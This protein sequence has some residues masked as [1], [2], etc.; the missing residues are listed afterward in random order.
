MPE[1]K[2]ANLAL[3]GGGTHGAFTW[4]VLQRL[5]EEPRFEI[6]GLSATSAGAMNAAVLAHGLTVGGR[7]AAMAALTSFWERVARLARGSFLQPSWYDRVTG[8]EGLEHSPSYVFLDM[9]SRVFSPYQ[10]NPFNYNPLR[11]LLEEMVD[12]E[13]LRREC[14]V[15]LFLCATNV[16]T[17]KVRVFG[18]DEISAA[19]VLASACVP[20]LSQAVEIEGEYFWDGGYMGNPALFPLIYECHS[21]DIV[22]VHVSPTERPDIPR[23]AQDIINRI[24]EISFNSSLFREMRAIAFVTRLIDEGRIS[25]GSLRRMLIHAIEAD[26][27]MQKLG[28]TSKLNADRSFSAP[29]ARGRPPPCRSVAAIAFR[30]DRSKIDH[31]HTI[32]ISVIADLQVGQDRCTAPRVTPIIAMVRRHGERGKRNMRNARGS[33]PPPL[34][35]RSP[36]IASL[37]KRLLA[38]RGVAPERSMADHRGRP[39][40]R[41]ACARRPPPFGGSYRRACALVAFLISTPVTAAYAGPSYLVWSIAHERMVMGW[42]CAEPRCGWT[43]AGYGCSPRLA[44]RSA[45]HSRSGN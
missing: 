9:L 2:I 25:D 3:Q 20:L 17:G 30:D 14:A 38:G 12:F 24:N 26:D 11:S 36:A 40:T 18:N 32:E 37:A 43:V 13:R 34:R 10:L 1:Q 23:T 6:E 22:V 42:R 27:V 44:M 29:A 8:D 4:G 41:P 45:H 21:R 33:I 19:H 31:R 15:K 39:P 7:D 5:L 16:R 35:G 28:A